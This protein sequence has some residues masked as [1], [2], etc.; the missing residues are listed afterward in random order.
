MEK[1]SI[2]KSEIEKQPLTFPHQARQHNSDF[3]DQKSL[4]SVNNSG[5]K[6]NLS[7]QNKYEYASEGND[8]SEQSV[9]SGLRHER[10][11]KR[12]T[13]AFKSMKE[14]NLENLNRTN[15]FLEGI[16]VS[17]KSNIQIKSNNAQ[18]SFGIQ[19]PQKVESNPSL[20]YTANK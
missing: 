4:N 14:N 17:K 8:K 9:H 1:V 6:E 5:N 11:R 18:I 16:S 12:S 2:T 20:M 3:L 19:S 10:R 7:F 13:S 15:K